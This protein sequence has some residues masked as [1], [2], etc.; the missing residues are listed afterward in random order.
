MKWVTLKKALVPALVTAQ[1]CCASFAHAFSNQNS[2][3]QLTPTNGPER[4]E[5]SINLTSGPPAELMKG[6]TQGPAV[7]EAG[8]IGVGQK[9]QG[10]PAAMS[11]QEMMKQ[12]LKSRGLAP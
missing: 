12:H 10:A 7:S 5:A 3:A 9:T 1:L 6:L 8:S 11:Q 2:G 4:V